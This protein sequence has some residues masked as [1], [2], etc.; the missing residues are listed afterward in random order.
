MNRITQQS[1]ERLDALLIKLAQSS[2]WDDKEE[3]DRAQAEARK[4]ILAIVR[5]V[6]KKQFQSLAPEYRQRI[7]YVFREWRVRTLARH[8][9]IGKSDEPFKWVIKGELSAHLSQDEVAS[10]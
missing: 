3:S 7:N 4:E 8:G 10:K 1:G 6:W 2:I 9:F 5:R